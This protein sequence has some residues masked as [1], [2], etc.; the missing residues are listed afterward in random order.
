MAILSAQLGHASSSAAVEE[1]G[2]AA[3][4]CVVDMQAHAEHEQHNANS[5]VGVV[6]DDAPGARALE[7]KLA[8]ECEALVQST[9]APLP[10]EERPTQERADVPDAGDADDDAP[11]AAAAGDAPEEPPATFDIHEAFDGPPPV[12]YRRPHPRRW[13]SRAFDEKADDNATGGADA[14]VWP[15]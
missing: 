10:P 8:R 11:G 13:S 15:A 6:A 12:P 9:A 4:D 14:G 2:G 3:A 7:L 5:P 1:S